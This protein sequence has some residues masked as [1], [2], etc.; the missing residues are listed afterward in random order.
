[1]P[2]AGWKKLGILYSADAYGEDDTTTCASSLRALSSTAN[3]FPANSTDLKPQLAKL[4]SA[5]VDAI[6]MHGYG[7]PSAIVY[8]NARE[9]GTWRRR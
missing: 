5:G 4:K 2:G 1:M 3:G 6:F 8:K 9:H 7:A